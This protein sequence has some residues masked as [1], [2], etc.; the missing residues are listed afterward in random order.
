MQ[1]RTIR[2]FMRLEASAGIILFVAAVLAL[3]VDNSP[4]MHIYENYLEYK[5]GFSIG[6]LHLV[7]PLI[8]WVNEGL[9]MVFFLLVGLE[10]KRELFEGEL[11]G[12]AKA[13]LPAFAA[14]GGMVLP[15]LIYVY[16]NK[17]DA[18]ALRGWAIPTATDI[19]FSLGILSLLGARVAPSL[20]VFLTALAIFDD[21]GG[22]VIIALFYTAHIAWV[23]L[24]A[25]AVCLLLLFILNRCQVCKTWPYILVGLFLW[26]F[27][28]KSGVH[29]TLAG[30]ALGFA[31][32]LRSKANPELSPARNWEHA[33]HPWVAFLILPIF[34]FCNAGV[35]FAGMHPVDI[36][37]P[38]PLGIAAGLLFGKQFGIW[39][40]VWLAI[41]FKC[42]K[43]PHGAS[44]RGI[45]GIGLI[46]GVGFTMSLFIGT[47]AFGQLSPEYLTAVRLGVLVGSFVS[48]LLGYLLLR[49]EPLKQIMVV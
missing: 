34:A 48:G 2:E 9:M 49:S 43:M 35:S 47:L 29:A 16:F 26:L 25:A 32:P 31:V 41:K 15:A 38:I 42:A 20:K 6:W 22:I 5:L 21:I 17:A 23:L 44:W 40:S 8:L 3:I 1:F 30:V 45:Y 28:L 18:T 24:L 39:L 46:A 12:W 10:V 11:H 7:K 14:V 4:L 33:L 19:A 13:S 36:L 37:A 27:V